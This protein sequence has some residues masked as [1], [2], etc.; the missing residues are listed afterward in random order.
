M[1]FD[2]RPPEAGAFSWFGSDPVR[3][4]GLRD[5]RCCCEG[6]STIGLRGSEPVR[7]MAWFHHNDGSEGQC[8][9]DSGEDMSRL[10]HRQK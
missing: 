9:R 10:H 2:I 8:Q 3:D 1:V 5:G 4:A 6:S 7:V